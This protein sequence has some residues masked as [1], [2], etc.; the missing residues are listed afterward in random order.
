MP[1]PFYIVLFFFNAR[2]Q[3]FVKGIDEDDPDWL[4]EIYVEGGEPTGFV[5]SKNVMS[6]WEQK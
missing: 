4:R 1:D 6:S 3:I 5:V 2:F